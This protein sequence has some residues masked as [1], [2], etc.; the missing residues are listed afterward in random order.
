MKLKKYIKAIRSKYDPVRIIF[1]NIHLKHKTRLSNYNISQIN[2]I[3]F[4]YSIPNSTQIISVL[5]KE[6]VILCNSNEFIKNNY[7]DKESSEKLKILGYIYSNNFRPPPNYISLDKYSRDIMFKLL[8]NKQQLIDRY[9]Y[10]KLQKEKDLKCENIEDYED[11]YINLK[12]LYDYSNEDKNVINDNLFSKK[13]NSKNKPKINLKNTK[14]KLLKNVHFSKENFNLKS[15]ISLDDESKFESK[16]VSKMDQIDIKE[17]EEKDENSIDSVMKLI[18]TFQKNN[19]ENNLNKSKNN[20]NHGIIYKFKNNKNN[21]STRLFERI[22]KRGMTGEMLISQNKIISLIKKYRHN[23]GKNNKYYLSVEN[24]REKLKEN[25]KLKDYLQNY[26][27][28]NKNFV[29]NLIENKNIKIKDK[30]LYPNFSS[31]FN[32]TSEDTIPKNIK[33][34]YLLS[35]TQKSKIS[36]FSVNSKLSYLSPQ[37]QGNICFNNYKLNLYLNINRNKL[38]TN[39]FENKKST[40]E[41]IM[42]IRNN[43]D[44]MKNK[45]FY[46]IIPYPKINN[47]TNK[48]NMTSKNKKNKILSFLPLNIKKHSNFRYRRKNSFNLVNKYNYFGSSFLSNENNNFKSFEYI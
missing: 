19:K 1:G 12:F 5:Y 17:K 45:K 33:I 46:C 29:T 8:K 24:F 22:N 38:N 7:S 37:S 30:V 31:K 15:Y 40:S 6:M 21:S 20:Q 34:N 36:N 27:K 11:N 23:F 48:V 42:K 9:N 3:L 13:S 14:G 39:I 28:I 4:N 35:P 2:S 16:G 43:S 25:K 26:W 18:D 44:F 47:L 10:Y 32:Y 41:L